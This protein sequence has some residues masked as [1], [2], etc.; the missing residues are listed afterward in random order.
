MKRNPDLLCHEDSV[1]LIRYILI[2][3]EYE[4]KDNGHSL[5]CALHFDSSDRWLWKLKSQIKGH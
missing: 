2:F 3:D 1:C 5:A 4:K